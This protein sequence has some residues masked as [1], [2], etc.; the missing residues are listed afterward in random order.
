MFAFAPDHLEFI[1][2]E[3]ALRDAVIKRDPDNIEANYNKALMLLSIGE[4][5]EG[6]K[7][8]DWRLKV[9]NSIFS[10]DWFPVKRWDGKDISGKHVLV[11]LEQ[12]VGDQI[13]GASMIAELAEKAASVILM[14]DRRF[15]PLFRRSFPENVTFYRFGDKIPDRM[16]K[17]DF[18]CQLSMT[19]LGQ[20]FRRTFDEFPGKPFLKPDP[21]KVAALRKKYKGYS[22][23]PLVGFSWMSANVK[24]GALKSIPPDEYIRLFEHKTVQ[25]V[26]LQYGD[27]PIDM[28]ILRD[29]GAQFYVD[30]SIDPLISLDDSAAQ[31]AAMDLVISVSNSTVHLAGAM[32]IPTLAMIPVGH[33]RVWYWFTGM[34][35]SVWYPSVSL[36]RTKRPDDWA[37][38]IDVAKEALN[39]LVIKNMAKRYENAA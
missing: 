37:P 4:F 27:N 24:Y 29:K 6:W 30:Q 9:P 20:M 21:E 10:Y 28:K 5:A 35:R 25:F 8:F 17:W 32:G 22:D 19:E 38:V 11:W 39:E 14:A 34:D 2:R 18:D 26:S 15:A 23:V 7:L 13:M 1:H 31:I 36:I 16:Q 12:G 3:I 33:G